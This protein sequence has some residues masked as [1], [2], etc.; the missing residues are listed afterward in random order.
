MEALL[1][2]DVLESIK[3]IVKME[4]YVKNTDLPLPCSMASNRM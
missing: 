3:E 2:Y 4:G 1:V